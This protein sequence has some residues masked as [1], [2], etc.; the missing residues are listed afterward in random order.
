MSSRRTSLDSYLNNTTT[1]VFSSSTLLDGSVRTTPGDAPLVGLFAASD[2]HHNRPIKATS[3]NYVPE[4][5]DLGVYPAAATIADDDAHDRRPFSPQKG[6]RRSATYNNVSRLCM[7]GVGPSHATT[8]TTTT[9][10]SERLVFDDH[11]AQMYSSQSHQHQQELFE[12]E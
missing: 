9:T 12:M 1:T 6:L 4:L 10:L 8:T 3:L 2:H 7:G 11:Y 5:D